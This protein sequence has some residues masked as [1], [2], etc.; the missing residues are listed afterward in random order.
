MRQLA[1]AL[2]VEESQRSYLLRWLPQLNDG[3]YSRVRQLAVRAFELVPAAMARRAGLRP[4][5]SRALSSF[6]HGKAM[7]KTSE[8]L[9]GMIQEDNGGAVRGASPDAVDRNL[10]LMREVDWLVWNQPSWQHGAH[11]GFYA[12]RT[13]RPG[14]ALIAAVSAFIDEVIN[15]R[16]KILNARA[17]AESERATTVPRSRGTNAVS[18]AVL[19]PLPLSKSGTDGPPDLASP[20]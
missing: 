1:L 11:G 18:G 5:L 10:N 14:A 15:R 2:S 12:C 19:D 8:Q 16:W 6:R 20:A 7:R 17:R 9:A 3:E 13:I 4:L